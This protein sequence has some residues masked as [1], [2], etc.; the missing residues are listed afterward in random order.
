MKLG[1]TVQLWQEGDQFIAHAMPLDV[2]SSGTTPAKARKA[3]KEAVTL[4]LDTAKQMGTLEQVLE[5]TGYTRGAR[6]WSSPKWLKTEKAVTLLS[7]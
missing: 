6:G 4:F 1:Y 5:E 2:A 7:A 3:L